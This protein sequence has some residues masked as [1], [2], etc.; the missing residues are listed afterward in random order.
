MAS[1]QLSFGLLATTFVSIASFA[2]SLPASS[3]VSRDSKAGVPLFDAETVQ[4]TDESIGRIDPKY[5]DLFAFDDGKPKAAS[6]SSCKILP[7]DP[8]WPSDDVWDQFNTLLD[9]ALLPIIPVAS[10][11]Y[12]DSPYNNYD[13]DKCA[14]IV[15]DWTTSELQY[16]YPKYLVF[17]T[18]TGAIDF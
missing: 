2:H 18:Q 3:V 10:P 5:A 8:E 4:L 14:E 9:G 6:W 13:A 17:Y 16:V 1:S 12:E 7:G 15:Q 11:C